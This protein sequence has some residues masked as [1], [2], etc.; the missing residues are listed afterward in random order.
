[1]EDGNVIVVGGLEEN[2]NAPRETL[3]EGQKKAQGQVE[4]KPDALPVGAGPAP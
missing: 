1:M 2:P 3:S 4:K